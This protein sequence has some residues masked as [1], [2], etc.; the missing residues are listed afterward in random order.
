MSQR[1]TL[2]LVSLLALAVLGVAQNPPQT[3]TQPA[4]AQA[5]PSAVIGPA[6]IAFVRIQDAVG[7]CEE[8]KKE[9]ATLQQYIDAKSN[10]L[11]GKQK[12]LETLKNQFDVMGTKLTDEARADMADSIETKDTEL[13][14]FQQDTQKD[15]DKK[16]QSMQN[17]IARKVL[18][19]IDKV[20][21]EKSLSWVG[22]VDP[23][24]DGYIDPSLDITQDVIKAYNVAFPVAAA[25]APVK[26]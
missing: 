2:L 17:A 20:A 4:A 15:I 16:R 11:Q 6:K 18:T 1:L 10:E 14:R 7:M 3:P 23:N 19:V 24:R 21:K 25:A 26:K 22:F 5:A 12:A 13:Q 8:G 9:S